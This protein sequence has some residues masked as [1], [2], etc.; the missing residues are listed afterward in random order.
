MDIGFAGAFLGGVLTLLS[1]CS[2]MLLP[3]FFAYAFADRSRL[4]ARTG[5]FFLGLLTT[6][7]PLGVL[8]GTFGAFV[9]TNRHTFVVVASVIVIALGV[10]QLLGLR[11]PQFTRSAAAE[12]T[13]TLAVFVLGLVYGIAGVCAGPMLGAVLTVAAL[14]GNA[15]YGG[16]VLVVFA[17]GMVLPLIAI[18]A[19]WTRIPKSW[20]RPREIKI[21]RWRNAVSS[22]VAGAIMIAIGILLLVTEGTAGLGGVL[23]PSDQ[24]RL[25]SDAMRAGASVSDL[26]FAAIALAVLVIGAT[27]YAV[28]KKRKS[29]V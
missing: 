23:S 1:P 27:I 20:L 7:V 14:G 21:G 6:L 22:V 3:A 29:S 28:A 12:G 26:V 18:A 16:L 4:F 9:M 25:E 11:M 19:L 2:V 8:A 5:L 15:L 13:S 17:V 10:V 24:I